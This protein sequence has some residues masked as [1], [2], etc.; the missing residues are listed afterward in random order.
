[1]LLALW[2]LLLGLGI[3]VPP[4]IGLLWAV[5]AA[6]VM[7]PW[8]LAVFGMVFRNFGP[9]LAAYW[10]CFL[11]IQVCDEDFDYDDGSD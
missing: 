5:P 11:R 3:F 6:L 4:L 1:M 7:T 9:L 8:V 10:W 2:C